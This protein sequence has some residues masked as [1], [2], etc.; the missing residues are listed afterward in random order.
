MTDINSASPTVDGIPP[1]Y[2]YL[3]LSRSISQPEHA[4]ISTAQVDTV[5]RY[6]EATG[7]ELEITVEKADGTRVTL[8]L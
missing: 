4:D 3:I 7:A 5:R 6:V 8:A 1:P 2:Q